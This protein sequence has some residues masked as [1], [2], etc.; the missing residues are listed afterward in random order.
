MQASKMKIF[1]SASR[2]VQGRGAIDELGQHIAKIGTHALIL[3]QEF[4]INLIGKRI[5]ASLEAAKVEVAAVDSSVTMCTYPTID[6]LVELGKKN[7]ANVVLGV[8][9][10]V[11]VDT[12][13]AVAHKLGIPV[14]SI[15]TQCATNADASALSVIYTEKHEWLEYLF[16]PK[17]P[18]LVL[19]DPEVLATAPAKFTVWGMGDALAANVEAK[20]CVA[21]PNAASLLNGRPTAAASWLGDL[22]ESNLLQYGYRAYRD[23]SKKLVTP[24][25]E[26][27]FESIKLL[28]S[29]CAESAG[30]AAAHAIHNGLTFI[31][32][33]NS[34][35]GEIVAFCV[36]VQKILENK[37]PKDIEPL[38]AWQ[39]KLGLPIT[40]EELGKIDVKE[41]PTAAEKACDP[42]DSMG[43]MPIRVTPG[44][45]HD[46]IL[47]ADNWGHEY[48]DT[49]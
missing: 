7:K 42:K 32:G 21:Q 8:G 22:C 37:K 11:A 44:M 19:V 6:A 31:H 9:G 27:I 18:D 20:A 3:G 28:S 26:R 23:L 47:A 34:N 13:K 41:L 46:A 29:L 4:P 45:V 40:L 24:F 5:V 14:A 17:N 25:V 49:H 12:G 16:Y 30:L 10:G 35:H 2:Y 1:G 36:N 48:H 15:P 39:H 38:M 33:V 43:N